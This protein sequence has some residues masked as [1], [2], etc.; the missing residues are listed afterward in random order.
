MS[1]IVV[2]TFVWALVL[3]AFLRRSFCPSLKRWSREIAFSPTEPMSR[4]QLFG[5]L[6]SG[7]FALL[8]RDNF[9]QIGSSLSERRIHAILQEHWA[10]DTHSDCTRVIQS[11][12]EGLGRMSPSEKRAIAAW[13]TRMP[14]DSN[15]Y[16]ALE[17]SCMFMARSALIVEVDELRRDH[18]SVLAW[19]I[20]QL[21]CLVRLGCA[22]DYLS[23][24]VAEEILGILTVRARARY[25]S[26]SDYSLAA[27][28]GIG[29]RG[30][31]EVF[32]RTEWARFARTHAVLLH[33]RRSPI[34]H[35]SRWSEVAEPRQAMRRSAGAATSWS[36]EVASAAAS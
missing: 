16:Q 6:L 30:S 1:T 5:C 13:L 15:A 10:I 21:A 20:Q 27:L 36:R 34:G 26:W 23:K 32:D 29:M 28:V 14:I 25:A 22:V 7:N 11:R 12:L 17:D 3:W 33:A 8:L 24:E 9:N 4:E 35:A 18:L 31:L 19:D 2:A